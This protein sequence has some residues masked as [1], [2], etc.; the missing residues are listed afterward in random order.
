[1]T[2]DM[3]QLRIKRSRDHE[4]FCTN[5]ECTDEGCFVFDI[6]GST[7][8]YVVEIYEHVD[9]WELCSCSCEDHAH[10]PYFCKHLCF[11]FRSLG[12]DDD[13]IE[14]FLRATPSQ[15]LLYELLSNAPNVV[16]RSCA[17]HQGLL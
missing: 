11:V 2:M 12:A 9:L 7:A 13:M 5:M 16:N 15:Q 14:T 4:I 6:V 8:E 10:R 1:M 17:F 3:Q